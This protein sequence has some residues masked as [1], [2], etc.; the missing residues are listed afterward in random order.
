[1][2]VNYPQDASKYSLS[3]INED[4]DIFPSDWCAVAVVSYEGPDEVVSWRQWITPA[5]GCVKVDIEKLAQTGN[6]GSSVCDDE[7]IVVSL[8]KLVVHVDPGME[9]D[10]EKLILKNKNF[11]LRMQV[12]KLSQ[13][14]QV[15]SSLF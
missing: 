6:V 7:V 1:M 5:Y 9:N 11:A 8:D 15:C 3:A 12:D 13:H 10:E 14:V 4:C 2:F